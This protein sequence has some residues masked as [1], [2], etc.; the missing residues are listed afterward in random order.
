[1]MRNYS[2]SDP[3]MGVPLREMMEQMFNDA[4]VMS[5][6]GRGSQ[7]SQRGDGGAME[8]PV[9][10]YES[11]TNLIVVLPLPGVSPNDIQVDVLGT[12]LHVR[13]EARRDEPH[14]DAGPDGGATGSG[15]RGR[16]SL[17]HEFRIGPYERTVE[18]PY[19]VDADRTDATY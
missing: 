10:M 2:R 9:N 7:Q 17:Q 19:N 11:K 16:R 1:M 15:D 14:E 8:A 3:F 12:Q 4:R 6:R 5:S 13:T 18:L